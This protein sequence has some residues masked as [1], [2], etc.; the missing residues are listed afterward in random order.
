[1]RLL[2]IMN[3]SRARYAGGA[4]QARHQTWLPYCAAGTKLE[5][6]YLPDKQER[7]EFGTAQAATKHSVLYPDRCV[8]AEREGYD[9]VI[10]HCCSDPGLE[11]A[12]RRVSIPVIGPGEATLRAGAILGQR[13]GM[14]VPGRDSI[15]HHGE[16][17][18]GL[19]L[20]DRVIGLEPIN[21]PIGTYA[22]QDPKAMTDALVAA[23]AKLVAKGADVICP[24]GLA[25]I[26]VRVDATEVSE[27]IGVPVLDPALLAVRSAETLTAA[28]AGAR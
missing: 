17:V 26:P 16:Q 15:A 21:R 8:E 27:R 19:G 20:A 23:A 1:M 2:L 6:G 28:R 22:G 5:I 3:G 24:S 11:E 12:R 18:R 13:I 14:T 9:A 4:D 7:Y 10:M 25:F